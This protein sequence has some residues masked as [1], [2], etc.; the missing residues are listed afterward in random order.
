MHGCGFLSSRYYP[1]GTSIPGY[2]KSLV[3]DCL[4]QLVGKLVMQGPNK[5]WL[6]DG[7][8]YTDYCPLWPSAGLPLVV[9]TEHGICRHTQVCTHALI[10]CIYR[11]VG[12]C[13]HVGMN[14]LKHVHM[15]VGT[16]RPAET[17]TE[18]RKSTFMCPR[19]PGFWY[20]G[21]TVLGF[22]VLGLLN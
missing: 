4:F 12:T 20:L 13:T 3:C 22:G 11:H 19:P 18:A 8:Q 10:V 21:F 9:D 16:H 15:H 7:Q 2:N 1:D 5:P 17:G 14:V 6:L